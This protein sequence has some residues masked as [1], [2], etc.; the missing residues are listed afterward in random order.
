MK[1]FVAIL[2]AL[3]LT[4][5]IALAGAETLTIGCTSVPHAEILEQA[6]AAL[7]EKGVELE[8]VV[9]DDYA[10]LNPY[11][12]D[13]DVD[14]NFFQH[15]PYLTDY[16]A[17]NG[18]NLVPLCA[19]HYEP[20]GIYGGKSKDLDAIADGAEIGVPN[21]AS[22]EVRALELLAALGLIKLPETYDTTLTVID[23]TGELNPKNL[24]LTEVAA[25]ALPRQLA[26][27][28]FAVIN[29]NYALAAGVEMVGNA[30]ATEGTDVSYPNVVAVR[31]GDE[32]PAF[33]VLTEVLQSDDMVNWIKET[34]GTAVVPSKTW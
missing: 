13:G 11:L 15:V 10:L 25:E 7:A 27:Y 16:N 14:A 12:K 29:S 24:K 19:V 34:Y 28:D 22:N 5:A 32:N 9:V 30:L 23:I 20:M 3:V 6:K 17:N 21:D 33:A 31:E 26:D 2:L 18:T 1:K 8:L 4:S